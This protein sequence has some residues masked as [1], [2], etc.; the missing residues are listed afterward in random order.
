MQL[1][2]DDITILLTGS[3]IAISCALPGSLLMLR[4]MALAGDAI[5][6]AVLPGI[7]LAFLLSGS[8]SSPFMIAGAATL[9]LF[10]TFSIE[11]LQKK[12]RL[13]ADASIGLT[14]TFLFAIG[15]ILLSMLAGKIDLDQDCVLYGELAYVPLDVWVTSSGVVLGPRALYITAILMML[16]IALFTICWRPLLLTTFD[17]AYAAAVG[18][19]TAFYHYLLMG[20]VSVTTVVS[21][22]LVG[23]ILVVALLIGPAATAY[24]LTDNFKR[25]LLVACITGVLAVTG[26]YYIAA[27]ADAS[28]AGAIAMVNGLLFLL[29][30]LFSPRYGLLLGKKR[31][32]IIH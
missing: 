4:R 12:A 26:G 14:F 18:V 19:N 15:V 16:L 21:F 25:L 11:V 32:T 6:H 24:M 22:E 9:G 20:S 28:I 2:Y 30:F 17:P 1:N 3:L 29:A 7:V 27:K 8:R 13:Q 5:A 31:S 10:T 23:A